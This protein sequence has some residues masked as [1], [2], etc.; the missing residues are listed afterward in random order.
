MA[1]ARDEQRRANFYIYGMNE[2]ETY[3]T[4]EAWSRTAAAALR[5]VPGVD[6][7]HV[8]DL[9]LDLHVRGRRVQADITTFYAAYRSAPDQQPLIL[10]ELVQSLVAVPVEPDSIDPQALLARV[11]PMVKPLALLNEVYERKLPMLAYRLL[12]GELL[13]A[14][15]IDEGDS[16]GYLN[17]GHLRMWNI[18]EVE[19][20]E[21]A[22]ANL[23][24]KAWTPY[25]GVLGAGKGALMIFNSR[26]GYDAARIVLPELFAEFAAR[27]PG[28]LVVGVPNRDFL[29]AFSDAN[30]R[31][32]DQIAAQV[33]TDAQTQAHALTAQLFTFEDGQ[34]VVYDAPHGG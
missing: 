31:V 30:R 28:T 29:I 22:L 12:A 19:L 26:D 23:R 2:Q 13:V 10:Q 25:P 33:A 5:D 9:L 32:F 11:M 21:R 34:L 24:A 4:P 6:I 14:Y 27:L 8:D 17:E 15:V 7:V 16:V 3:Q 1:H 18:G 20:H